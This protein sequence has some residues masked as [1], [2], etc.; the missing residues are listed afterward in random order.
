[1]TITSR[2][3]QDGTQLRPV[4]PPPRQPLPPHRLAKLANALGVSTPLPATGPIPTRISPVPSPSFSDANLMFRSSTP[5]A[6]SVHTVTTSMTSKF[7]LHI[8]PP[9]D[10]AQAADESRYTPLPVSASGYHSQYERGTLVPL[11]QSLQGQL[12]AIAKE[13]ALPS[14]IGLVLYLVSSTPGP[15]TVNPTPYRDATLQEWENEGQGPRISEAIWRHIWIRVL[16]VEKEDSVPFSSRAGT[17]D[18]GC[19]A[20]QSSPSLLDSTAMSSS[21][22]PLVSTSRLDVLTNPGYPITPS[23]TTPPSSILDINRSQ[24]HLRRAAARSL[25]IPIDRELLSSPALTEPSPNPDA[26]DIPGLHSNSFIPVLAKVEFV[27]DQTKATWY[28]PW[29]RSRRLNHAKRAESRARGA[30]FNNG[31]ASEDDRRAPINLRLVDKAQAEADVHGFLRKVEDYLRLEDDEDTSGTTKGEGYS[32]LD[33]DEDDDDDDE[34]DDEEITAQFPPVP[35][36]KDP[37]ADV[38]G[39]DADTWAEIHADNRPV[40]KSNS[41]VVDLALDGAALAEDLLPGEN[42]TPQPNDEEEVKELWEGQ[43]RPRLSVTIPNSPPNTALDT[44]NRK[45]APPPLNLSAVTPG[46][47][48]GLPV[49]LTSPLP[50][51]GDE[52][53]GLPYLQGGTPLEGIFTTSEG[54]ELTLEVTEAEEVTRGPVQDKRDGA[55]FEGLDLG[56]S[57][58]IDDTVIGVPLL[59]PPFLR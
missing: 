3:S 32:Q 49:I 36:A 20:S 28:E 48:L 16:K 9:K 37:L 46:T 38:F 34:L 44:S 5:S 50:S 22:K 19:I 35:G 47:A 18:V 41:N 26:I 7:L 27:I 55:F 1:M 11:H 53:A 12:T 6:S 10:L 33:E 14:T 40:R 56:L 4:W 51:S 23:P 29:L 8:V 58:D 15:N 57:F 59:S 43:S 42:D 2:T 13:Y 21:L 54:E 31:E 30:S 39:T 52:S 17:P 24:S 25:T 45:S